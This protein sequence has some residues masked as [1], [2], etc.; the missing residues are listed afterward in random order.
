[1]SRQALIDSKFSSVICAPVFTQ[2]AKL[3]TQLEVGPEEEMLHASWIMCD[4][5]VAF[6]KSEL[7]NYMG[8]LGPLK[9]AGLN[10]ARKISLDLP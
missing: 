4:R 6:L 3:A 10:R 9:L 2:G 8:P 5:L 7:T 1:V